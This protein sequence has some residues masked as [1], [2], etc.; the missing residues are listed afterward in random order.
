MFL[1]ASCD[2]RTKALRRGGVVGG[3]ESGYWIKSSQSRNVI[4]FHRIHPIVAERR[5]LALNDF[6]STY[7]S[8]FQ[9]I[10][11]KEGYRNGELILSGDREVS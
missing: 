4:S 9:T 8:T 3:K 2:T 1:A 10:T 11:P 7:L 5:D 6:T